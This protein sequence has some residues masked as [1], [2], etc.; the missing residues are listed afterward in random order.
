VLCAR[1]RANPQSPGNKQVLN[2]RQLTLREIMLS[3]RV[4]H[5]CADFSKVS[6]VHKLLLPAPDS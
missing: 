2:A 6:I 1:P 4:C 5:M 3:G